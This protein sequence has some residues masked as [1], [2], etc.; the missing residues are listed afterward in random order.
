VPGSVAEFVTLAQFRDAVPLN[1]EFV[2]VDQFLQPR[3]RRLVGPPGVMR[4]AASSKNSEKFP[5]AI[6]AR[7]RIG[8]S[9]AFQNVCH[10]SRPLTTNSPA[11]TVGI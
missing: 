2:L 8:S 7:N 5:G 6:I 4:S 1:F 11:E 9:P 3:H 10:T